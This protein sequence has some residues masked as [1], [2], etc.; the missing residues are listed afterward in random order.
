MI[1]KIKPLNEKL[2][3]IGIVLEFLDSFQWVS[4]HGYNNFAR[5][6]DCTV[7]KYYAFH[8]SNIT[9]LFSNLPITSYS[10]KGVG[11]VGS[12]WRGNDIGDRNITIS[13]DNVFTTN[14]D[15]SP[16]EILNVMANNPRQLIKI[17]IYLDND[18]PHEMI[19]YFLNDT[20]TANGFLSLKS[21]FSGEGAYFSKGFETIKEYFYNQYPYIEN[22]VNNLKISDDLYPMN[23]LVTSLVKQKAKLTIGGEKYGDW[24]AI[25]IKQGTKELFYDKTG[26]TSKYLIIDSFNETITDENGLDV[27][28]RVGIISGDNKLITLE[29]GFNNFTFKIDEDDSDLG[30]LNKFPVDMRIEIE[31]NKLSNTIG[32]KNECQ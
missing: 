26:L 28:D 18:S 31:R 1:V 30:E 10:E 13:F 8:M 3:E 29:Q 5:C 9:G 23:V 27:S 6:Y 15:I 21:A 17:E 24:T 22:T 4:E 11:A 2:E 19:M 12:D 32:V 16:N 14:G 7:N 25:R 20:N